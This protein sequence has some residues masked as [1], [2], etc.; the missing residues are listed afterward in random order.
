M[1]VTSSNMYEVWKGPNVEIVYIPYEYVTK[2]QIEEY[3]DP[4][5][6]YYMF[7]KYWKL[8][9]VIALIYIIMIR[10]IENAMKEKRAFELKK[11]L[12]LW[13]TSLAIFSIIGMIRSGEEFLYVFFNKPFT[14]SIC[15]SMN[16]NEPVAF[17]AC[18]FALSKVAELFDTIFLVLRKRKV[19]FLHWYHHVVV[20]IYSWNSAVELTAAGRWFIFMNFSVHSIMYS[21]YALTSI[22]LRFPKIVSMAVTILQTSQ[23]LIGVAISCSVYYLRSVINMIPCQ[24]SYENLTL[25]FSIYLSF[26]ILFMNFFIKSYFSRKDK[27]KKE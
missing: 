26:A 12:F 19:I 25:C 21:Y 20:L 6:V 14:H 24:Q 15:Y 7:A 3:W 22:G 1:M 16:P 2:L 5:F 17:W 9:F 13:N 27:M 11:S 23:M 8:S 18:A 10:M 4:Y